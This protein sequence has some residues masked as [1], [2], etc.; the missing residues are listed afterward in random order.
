MKSRKPIRRTSRRKKALSS[1]EKLPNVRVLRAIGRVRQGRESNVG[2]GARAEGTTLQ[3]M[4]REAPDAL[5]LDRS[6][7][8]VGVKASDP[9]SAL[10][11]I[12]T[13]QGPLDVIAR[14]SRERELAGRHRAV[15][16]R[17]LRGEEPDSSLKQFRNETVGGHKLLTSP[18]RLSLLAEAGIPDQL[19]SLYVSP[20]TR[21]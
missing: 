17:V 19:E 6:G 1:Q 9:Y 5:V 11:E 2:A 18:Y 8:V 3:S 4:K 20:D 14:G 21:G 10:V 15:V 13:D 12:M 16:M 7:R